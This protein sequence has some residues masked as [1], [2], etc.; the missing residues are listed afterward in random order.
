MA[1]AKIGITVVFPAVVTG[2]QVLELILSSKIFRIH[3]RSVAI[4]ISTR[5]IGTPE[6]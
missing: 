5:V 1:F 6:F 4:L 3:I 2:L